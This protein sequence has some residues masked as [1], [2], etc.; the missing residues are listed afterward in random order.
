MKASE[1]FFKLGGTAWP[2]GVGGSILILIL[3]W[4]DVM[5]AD[6]FDWRLFGLLTGAGGLAAMIV[7]GVFSIWEN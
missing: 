7:G 6:R 3:H 5:N 4:L 1:F 2:I